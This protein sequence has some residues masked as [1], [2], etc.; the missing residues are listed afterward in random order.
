M[1]HSYQEIMN[2]NPRWLDTAVQSPSPITFGWVERIGESR[3]SLPDLNTSFTKHTWEWE[4][5]NIYKVF[6][7]L[8]GNLDTTV[9]IDKIVCFGLGFLSNTKP[10]AQRRSHIQHASALTMASTLVKRHTHQNPIRIY[11]QDPSYTDLDKTFLSSIGITVLD[12]PKGFL[13]ADEQTLVFSVS[14]DVCVRQIVADLTLPAAMVWNTVSDDTNEKT[15]WRE[16]EMWGQMV[17]VA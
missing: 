4:Q 10:S 2:P 12:D 5:S 7:Q 15:E 8:L 1:Y 16:E 9:Q 17:W 11:A 13:K 6:K 3:F 14:P